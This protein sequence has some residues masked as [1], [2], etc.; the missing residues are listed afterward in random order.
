VTNAGGPGILLADA[1]EARGL[2]LPE[3]AAETV[4]DLRAFL[5]PQAGVRNPVDMI[6]SATPDDFARAIARVG[7]DPNVD[8]VVVIYVPPVATRSEEVAAAVARGAGDVPRDKP[9][10]TVFLS[11]KGAPEV[12]A[13]GPRGRLPSFSFPENAARA[14]AAAEGYGRWKRRPQ[15]RELR[16]SGEARAAVRALVDQALEG[17]GEAR[18]LAPA[19]VESLLRAVGVPVAEAVT[20]SLATAVGV[21]DRMGYPLVAKAVAPGLLHKSDVGAVILGLDSAETVAAALEELHARLESRG[22]SLEGVLLQREVRGGIEAFVGALEDPIFGPLI[23]CGLGG[24]QVEL[25]RDASFRLP[26]VTDVDAREMIDRLRGKPLFDGYRGSPP[27]D[28]EAL[29]SI[30]QRVSALVEAAPELCELDLNPVKVLAPGQGAV[31]LDA[32]IRLRS[33]QERGL[34]SASRDESPVD[35]QATDAC[36]AISS[37][38]PFPSPREC[39]RE[40]HPVPVMAS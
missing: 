11:S 16:L 2:L 34:E 31:V 27:G 23:V 22:L 36:G 18:W 39:G 10:L 29:V 5:P 1:C 15:G 13:S 25:L 21:A 17:C 37:S 8:S 35:A 32:R 9:V 12:L 28:R 26:P 40:G 4:A 24:V 33:P 20:A 7:R 30:L 3:L 19:E 14:L 6:A 38:Q